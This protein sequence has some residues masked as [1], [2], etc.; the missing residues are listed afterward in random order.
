MIS[1]WLTVS[2][3]RYDWMRS[4]SQARGQI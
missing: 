2:R 4:P 1:R 3:R